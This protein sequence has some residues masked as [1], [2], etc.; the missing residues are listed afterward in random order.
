MCTA[1]ENVEYHC[2]IVVISL[3]ISCENCRSTI[4]SKLSDFLDSSENC[5][6]IKLK[7][8]W[9]KGQL[10]ASPTHRSRTDLGIFL[11]QHRKAKSVNKK[12][13]WVL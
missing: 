1:C 8:R 5:K 9:K 2:E 3:W 7:I 13:N 6:G 4:D 12:A 10:G 11:A